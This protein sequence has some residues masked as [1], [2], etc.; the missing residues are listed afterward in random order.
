[1]LTWFKFDTL[2]PEEG[3]AIVVRSKR[4]L[5][6]LHY[7]I[8]TGEYAGKLKA[9]FSDVFLYETFPVHNSGIDEWTRDAEWCDYNEFMD[10]IKEASN[11]E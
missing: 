10:V 4:N 11:V 6:S 8:V 1:M 2:E 3:R 5:K 7:S 9:P